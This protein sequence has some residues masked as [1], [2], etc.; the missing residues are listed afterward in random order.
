MQRRPIQAFFI[1]VALPA[2][3]LCARASHERHLP[4]AVYLGI[5]GYGNLDFK[6]AENFEHRFY[7]DGSESSFRIS[8]ED[9]A[10]QNILAEGSVYDLTLKDGKL[11]A[12]LPSVPYAAGPVAPSGDTA[13]C[14][15]AGRSISPEAR[16]YGIERKSGGALVS[17]GSLAAGKNAEAYGKFGETVFL[18]SVVA[19]Y[20]APVRGV[21]GRRTL[22]NFLAT[23]MEPVGVT[24]YLYGGGWNWQDEGS[25]PQAVSIGLAQTWLD[26]FRSRDDRYAYKNERNPAA[27]YYPEGS[28]NE[29]YYAGLDC[30]GFVGWLVY[31]VMNTAS[32]RDGY[33]QNASGMAGALAE[34]YGFGVFSRN[35]A[36]FR[37]GDVFSMKGHIWV[38]LGV[39]EDGSL[40]IVHATPSRSRSGHPGGGVQLSGVGKSKD[41][42]AYQL[43]KEYMERYYPDWS[44]RY[45]PTFFTFEAYTKTEGG[46]SGKFSWY[47]D[48]RGLVDPDNYAGLSA[49]DILKNLFQDVSARAR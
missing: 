4:H 6:D 21:P 2:L 34:I 11:V 49:C 32:G 41:C 16:V 14:I 36:D 45:V 22:K 42:Q 1:L 46:D 27:S 29:Y 31:N 40:V 28:Y 43:A 38:C 35:A 9:Y 24:L 39:C 44:E 30:S 17:K 10:V 37:P 33:V 20:E 19:P 12:A 48:A 47:P 15:I 5:K 26:F 13:S 8:T 18:V 23:A 25:G 7:T 3:L